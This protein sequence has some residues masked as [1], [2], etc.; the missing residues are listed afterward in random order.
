MRSSNPRLTNSI[1][2][3]KINSKP[4]LFFCKL[5]QSDNGICYRTFSDN[6]SQFVRSKPF[7]LCYGN[8]FTR[9]TTRYPLLL[10]TFINMQNRMLT[11]GIIE[12]HFK[13]VF[14]QNIHCLLYT[15]LL[16]QFC[17]VCVILNFIKKHLL[18]VSMIGF[19]FFKLLSY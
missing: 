2:V 13:A 19:V 9:N 11:I 4:G 15:M 18:R 6:F 16:M 7:R 3:N 5:R 12:L 17:L 8:A 10:A 14:H 1:H